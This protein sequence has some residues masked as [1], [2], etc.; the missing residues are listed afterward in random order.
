[1][2]A[3]YIVVLVST[4]LV[5]LAAFSS[6]LA[7][8]FG[9]PLL[10]LFLMIGLAAG[11]DGLGIEFSN[12]YLAYILGSIALAVI[13]FDSGFG[14]PMQAFRLAAVPSLALASVGVLITASLFA[15]AAM[16]LL[17]F[18]WL[19]GLLLGSIVASTDAAAV[20]FLLRIGGINIRDKVR[21]TL[22][23]ESG[24]N[25]PM[26]IFLTIALVEV[27]A[28]GERY[29]GINIGMLAMFVQQ[30]GLGVILGLLGG[31]M[32]VLIV[33]RLD[34]DRG[35]TP[36][37]VLAL[38]LLVFSFTGAVGGSGFLAVYVAGI[39]AGNRKMQ[40]I[41]TIKRFQDGMTWLA[42][43]IM[44][45]VLGLLAT[46]S[47][48][49]VIIVPAILLALFLIF[50]ARPLAIWLSLLPFDYTQ[51]EIGFVAWVG[52]RGA[53][54]ILL[55]IMPIL[56]GLENGQIYFNTA[57][58]IVLV[59]LLLQGWTI[60]PV[61][62]KLGLIIPPRIGAV[63]KV[64]VD[65]PGAANHELLSYRVIKDSPVLRGERIPRWATPSLV[66]RDG[67]SMRYQYAGRLREHDLVYLFIVPSYSRLLDRLFASRAPVDDDD[68]EFF[69]AFALSPAR[70]AADLDAAYGPGLLNESERGLTIA[71]LMRQRLGGKADYA[72]RVRLG[73]I[74]L[75]VR[76]LDEHDHITS[77]GMSLE[78]V[79]PAIT[80]PIFLNLKDITQR[81][82]DRLNGR[83]NRETAASES[84]PKPPAGRDEG[85]RENG[86]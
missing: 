28:S 73:S 17:N 13:L 75:I 55:A 62:K 25:D 48:F 79:E 70:P 65:L 51:Q 30:M 37:F 31:M 86:R 8:R 81:I 46:P 16:W 58:I 83:R 45:L 59:S 52:L 12:N 9:A 10:L 3:F 4:A 18:T 6:L 82:R 40:A 60:K 29:A 21:S 20:F 32:I 71:E 14:T 36:I 19:E 74:I 63:D 54:S 85:T 39:Y 15:F 68:A 23:V 24:T 41:G 26:A 22:E 33:S 66:I 57:F 84:P 34:T 61:A 53:V 76:D 64:E 43:I 47:Q 7:F 2:E 49:P 5:L 1:M 35:L 72:D 67:K 56:G 50:V 11:V 44:F 38:A 27:L 77:V 42:Q 78:A 69:G 80:L